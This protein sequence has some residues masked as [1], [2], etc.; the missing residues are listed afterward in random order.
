MIF[1]SLRDIHDDMALVNKTYEIFDENTRINRSNAARVE[2]LTSV[3]I[4]GEYV[5]PGM[6]LLDVGAGAG[7]YSLYFEKSGM[8]VTAVEL[9]DRNIAAF[10][11]KLAPESGIPLIKGNALNLGFLPDEAFDAVLLM[12]PLY[13][14]HSKADRLRCI[15]EARRVCKKGGM[16]F[17]A[18]ISNDMVILTE[19]SYDKGFFG[20]D[21]YDHSSFKVEDY[22]FVF[23][24]PDE[25]EKLL[26]E[27]ALKPLRAVASDGVSELMA[28]RINELDEYGFNQYLRYHFYTCEKP[29]ML[30]RS[31]HLLYACKNVP[32]RSCEPGKCGFVCECCP[33]FT[34]GECAGCEK[35]H[36]QGDCFTRDC[37]KKRGIDFCPMCPDFP[38]DPLLSHE[39]CTVLSKEWLR[40]KKE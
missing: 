15:S 18:F 19:L 29:E 6:T 31:N 34:S 40:W 5:R 2:F 32:P 3:R 12:G 24:T 13:H 22:P 7:E 30:G 23:S 20:S 8:N 38:C 11:S 37:V 33:T 36:K 16:I 14:L 4:I 39:R 27:G 9:S 17:C 35:A 28:D 26:R 1:D 25:A 21:Q 10:R